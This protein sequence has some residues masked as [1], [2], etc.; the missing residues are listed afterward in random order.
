VGKNADF[1]PSLLC[2]VEREWKENQNLHKTSPQG[3]DPRARVLVIEVIEVSMFL[4]AFNYVI[5]SLSRP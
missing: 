3:R 4:C 2:R 5:K 1:L